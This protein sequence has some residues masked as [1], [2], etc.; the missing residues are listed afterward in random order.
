MEIT[1][2]LGLLSGLLL[3]FW[4]IASRGAVGTYWDPSAL[5]IVLGGTIAAVAVSHGASQVKRIPG[6]VLLVFKGKG[7]ARVETRDRL[8]HLAGKARRE[9]LLAMEDDLKEIEDPFLHEAVQLLVDATPPEDLRDVLQNQSYSDE[10]KGESG[11]GLFDTAAASSPAFG[12]IGTLIGLIHMLMNLSDPDGIGLG[13]AVA[14]IT[15]FYGSLFANLFFGPMARK[16]KEINEEE[17]QVK[18]MMITGITA[19]QEGKNPRMI[20]SLL[21]AFVEGSSVDD[22]EKERAERERKAGAA[23]RSAVASDD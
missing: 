17:Q 1:A 2:I 8:V 3:L 15:T 23:E 6:L 10:L 14:L 7:A 16:L 20:A 22:E 9:G 13:M 21:S 18:E 12:M 11:A 5:M 4:A 19:I